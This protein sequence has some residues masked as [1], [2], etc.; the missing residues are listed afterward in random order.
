MKKLLIFITYIFLIVTTIFAFDTSDVQKGTLPSNRKFGPVFLKWLQD[1]VDEELSKKE[2]KDIRFWIKTFDEQ[3]EKYKLDAEAVYTVNGIDMTRE[4][5]FVFAGNKNSFSAQLLEM[6]TYE[7]KTEGWGNNDYGNKKIMNSICK[8]NVTELENLAKKITDTEYEKAVRQIE[9]GRI[10]S[11]CVI[12]TSFKNLLTPEDCL[13]AYWKITDKKLTR[14]DYINFLKAC[15]NSIYVK[16]QDDEFEFENQIDKIKKEVDD[17]I[18][19]FDLSKN[20]QISQTVKFG[21]YNFDSEGYALSLDKDVLFV[22]RQDNGYAASENSDSYRSIVVKPENY[23]D[24]NF[25]P[26]KRLEAQ[27]LLE[28]RKY[29]NGYINRNIDTVINFHFLTADTKEY[30]QLAKYWNGRKEKL[31]SGDSFQIVENPI[32]FPIVIDSVDAFSSF[33]KDNLWGPPEKESG[34]AIDYFGEIKKN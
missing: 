13:I 34:F 18:K 7:T 19:N 6:I 29:D 31:S 10:C 1:S 3:N 8:T 16:Y 9:T 11:K 28:K 12:S 27:E 25:L 17:L 23:T 5:S 4:L 26:M 21:K 2:I 20:Y 32:T 22:I 14:S 15:R 33:T 30:K 24:F